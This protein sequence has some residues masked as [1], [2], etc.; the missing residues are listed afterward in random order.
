MTESNLLGYARKSNNGKAL[1]LNISVDA[2]ESSEK[3]SSSDGK[4]Y[5]SMIL[6]I[7]KVQDLIGGTKE[8]TGI[9]QLVS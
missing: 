5:V 8:V 9:V 6:N 7:N 3:Y 2:F 4:Q 1:K